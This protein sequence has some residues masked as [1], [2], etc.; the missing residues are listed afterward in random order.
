VSEVRPRSLTDSS[1]GVH[2]TCHPMC[3]K[4]R[5]MAQLNLSS[6]PGSRSR[7]VLSM[8][9]R[10]SRG[11]DLIIFANSFLSSTSRPRPSASP[12]AISVSRRGTGFW[13]H[14]CCANTASVVRTTSSLCTCSAATFTKSQGPELAHKNRMQGNDFV[15]SR[16][17]LRGVTCFTCH[18]VHGTANNA[19][20]REPA[21]SICL[22]CHGPTSNRSRSRGRALC[23]VETG[24]GKRHENGTAS[25]ARF[26]TSP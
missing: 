22:D 6:T 18:D 11:Q 7:A 19:D 13:N 5:L 3:Q 8:S 20:L 14:P 17:Y 26:Q 4:T 16:M 10:F 9:S 15:T 23:P 25:R 12:V 2:S 21:S 1:S 24:Y